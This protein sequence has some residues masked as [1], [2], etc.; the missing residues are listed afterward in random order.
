M[1]PLNIKAETI[2]IKEEDYYYKRELGQ[3]SFGVV[4]LFES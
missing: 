1:S 3:G 2:S 4:Y